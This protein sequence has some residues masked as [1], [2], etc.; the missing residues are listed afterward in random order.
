MDVEPGVTEHLTAIEPGAI[1]VACWPFSRH[2][3]AV[4][5]PMQRVTVRDPDRLYVSSDLSCPP[6]DMSW[7]SI[8]DFIDTSTGPYADPIEA[9]LDWVEERPGDEFRLAGYPDQP[10]GRPVIVIR[11]GSTVASVGVGRAD[12]GRWYIGGGSG[13]ESVRTAF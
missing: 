13:C 4:E 3:T 6:G 12:D 7:S 10:N 5:P 8:H 9:A 2:P 1:H 11:D